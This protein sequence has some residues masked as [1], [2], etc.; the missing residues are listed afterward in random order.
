MQIRFSSTATRFIMRLKKGETIKIET[1]D[2][3]PLWSSKLCDLDAVR[4]HMQGA[5]LVAFD[6]E[7]SRDSISE[8]GLAMLV[9][10]E[11]N[12]HYCIGRGRFYHHNKVQSFSVRLREK[13]TTGY[14]DKRYGETIT[15]A[16]E[17][18]IVPAMDEMLKRF[19]GQRNLILVGYDM[20]REFRWISECWP[21][22]ASYFSGWVD[23]QELVPAGSDRVQVSLNDALRACKIID[24]R[25]RIP[26][27]QHAPATDGVR[28]LA[29]LAALLDE[30][31]VNL[32]SPAT[33]PIKVYNCL[34]RPASLRPRGQFPFSARISTAA[35]SQLPLRTPTELCRMYSAFDLKAVGTNR[36]RGKATMT[37]WM[38]F[39]TSESLR[40]F[41]AEVDGS[42]VDEKELKVF[43]VIG[44]EEGSDL[45]EV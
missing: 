12:P 23:V 13:P 7:S 25:S 35:G 32:A 6:I 5:I 33:S 21:T 36:S 16:S 37:W 14:V 22:M 42:I 41:V 34:P 19:R 3:E 8:L 29:V 20:Y 44:L 9:V 45:A 40:D 38:A 28:S 1:K 27:N 2:I 4:K 15:I 31:E 10:D 26:S 39:N 17:K 43:S 30:R 11:N 18:E 24:D